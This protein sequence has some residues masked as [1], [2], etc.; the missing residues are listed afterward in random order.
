METEGEIMVV[1][2]K[3]TVDKDNQNSPS[4]SSRNFVFGTTKC[5]VL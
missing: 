4:H 5:R 2:E 1:R 3:I